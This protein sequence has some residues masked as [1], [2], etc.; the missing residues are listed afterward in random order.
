VNDYLLHIPAALHV[1]LSQRPGLTVR[2]RHLIA[3][4]KAGLFEA[5]VVSMRTED[6][7]V[8][9][10][11]GRHAG[12]FVPIKLGVMACPTGGRAEPIAIPEVSIRHPYTRISVG[13]TPGEVRVRF[14]TIRS[15]FQG[16]APRLE[17]LLR[18][19]PNKS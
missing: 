19:L 9:A 16:H 11:T 8:D 2:R 6:P 10:A 17:L 4:I 13:N 12:P 3:G 7:E 15:D 18:L 5:R 1:A 14:E